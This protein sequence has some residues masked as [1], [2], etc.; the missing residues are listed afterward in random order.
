MNHSQ[1]LNNVTFILHLNDSP[2]TQKIIGKADKH[3][4]EPQPREDFEK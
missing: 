1:R 4:T 2:A 3:N